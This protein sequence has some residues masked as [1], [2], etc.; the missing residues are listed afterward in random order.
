MNYK[1]IFFIYIILLLSACTN[2]KYLAPV[3]NKNISPENVKSISK[4]IKIYTGDSLYSIS[5]REGVSIRSIIEVNNLEPPFILYEGKELIIPISKIH[6]VQSGNTLWDI[7]NCYKV[8]VIEIRAL[9]NLKIKDKIYRG[10]KLFIPINEKNR[11]LRCKDTSKLIVKVD[12]RKKKILNKKNIVSNKTDYLWP[13]K[14]KILSKYGLL[15]KGLRNDGI[16]ISANKGDP[17]FASK[18]GKVVYA[19]NEIQAFGNLI[20]IKHYDNK[21]TA[22][23]HLDKIKVKKG[24][25]V[26]KGEVIAALGNSGKVSKPQLHFELRDSNGP[27]NPLKYLP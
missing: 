18:A 1:K 15:A 23:A 13:V 14:G 24:Q 2:N 4:T 21:T 3:I 5:K 9:N 16:N 25:A 26:K 19:G 12:K 20:L 10:K 22:Y 8:S 27:L 11:N 17:V 6:I 7:A